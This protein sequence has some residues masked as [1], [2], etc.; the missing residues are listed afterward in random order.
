VLREDGDASTIEIQPIQ[1]EWI[2]SL[3]EAVGAVAE[4]RHYLNTVKAF[5][6][7]ETQAFVK[8][9]LDGGGVQFVALDGS[10]VV[11]WCDVVRNQYEGMRHSGLLGM[12]ILRE[13]RH[14]R[15][16]AELLR[17]TLEGAKE[18]GIERVELEVFSSNERA[19]QLYERTGFVLEGR[20]RRARILDDV[21]TDILM[22]AKF[23]S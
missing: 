14:Q 2:Q 4:E 17:R 16:G 10:R 15:I 12:G 19:I 7:D 20:K 9:L 11:G 21:E 23:L 6:L 22:M 18:G 5:S 13:F 8:M 1:D 3:R